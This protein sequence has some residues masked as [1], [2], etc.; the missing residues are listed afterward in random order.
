MRPIS[1]GFG[2]GIWKLRAVP[3]V[4]LNGEDRIS[5][6]L[7]IDDR[8]LRRWFGLDLAPTLTYPPVIPVAKLRLER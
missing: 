5:E 2:T 7:A 8:S 3:A 6:I 4:H 1:R